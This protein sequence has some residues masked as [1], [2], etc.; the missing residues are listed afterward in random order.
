MRATNAVIRAS[1][2]G[3]GI[4]FVS[5]VWFALFFNV[6]MEGKIG[7]GL[8]FVALLTAVYWTVGSFMEA[9]EHRSDL[10]GTSSAGR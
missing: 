2:W 6:W 4:K 10:T 8:L 3:R 1:H 9:F 7:V 5:S